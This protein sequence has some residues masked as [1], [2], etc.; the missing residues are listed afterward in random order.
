MFNLLREIFF[1]TRLQHEKRQSQ[2][3][4]TSGGGV[5]IGTDPVG[6]I[7]NFPKVSFSGTQ[8]PNSKNRICP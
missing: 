6:Q 1:F 7:R 3:G 5:K 8:A 4:F 2:F